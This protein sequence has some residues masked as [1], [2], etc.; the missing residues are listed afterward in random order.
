MYK[1][2]TI[3]HYAFIFCATEE[4]LNDEYMKTYDCFYKGKIKDLK[5]EDASKIAQI[6]PKAPEYYELAMMPLFQGKG[7]IM[8]GTESPVLALESYK[9]PKEKN[10]KYILIWKMFN[11]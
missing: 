9:S 7:K 3:G 5:Y 6:H 10:M 4:D 2:K 8:K 1:I 11:T